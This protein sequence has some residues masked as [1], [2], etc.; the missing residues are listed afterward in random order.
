MTERK[1]GVI[2]VSD[3]GKST[4][5]PT[6]T[7][8]IPMPPGAALPAQANQPQNAPAQPPSNPTEGMR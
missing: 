7:V 6:V 8:N 5:M 1:F 3:L 2:S 4:I